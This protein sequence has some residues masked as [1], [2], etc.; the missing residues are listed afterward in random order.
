[1]STT[2]TNCSTTYKDL[3]QTN[4]PPLVDV[5]D[6]FDFRKFGE[7]NNTIYPHLDSTKLTSGTFLEIPNQSTLIARLDDYV[8]DDTKFYKNELEIRNINAS[9]FQI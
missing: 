8:K 1:V 6:V 5:N 4:L 7:N 9:A 2:L 3:N